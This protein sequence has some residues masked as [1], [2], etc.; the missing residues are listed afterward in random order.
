[1]LTVVSGV[2]MAK[3]LPSQLSQADLGI[4]FRAPQFP[5]ILGQIDSFYIKSMKSSHHFSRQNQNIP[6]E[7]AKQQQ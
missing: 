4:P 2:S 6:K 5:S 3:N 1:M 7:L